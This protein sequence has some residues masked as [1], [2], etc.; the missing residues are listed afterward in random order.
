MKLN[1][2]AKTEIDA[3]TEADMEWEATLHMHAADG[4]FAS[5]GKEVAAEYEDGKTD[6]L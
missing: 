2:L 4:T 6:P 1:E 3:V 5:I